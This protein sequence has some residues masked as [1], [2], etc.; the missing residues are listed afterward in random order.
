LLGMTGVLEDAKMQEGI[1]RDGGATCYASAVADPDDCFAQGIQGDKCTPY[2]CRLTLH[3]ADPRRAVAGG[4][5]I[6][7][8]LRFMEEKRRQSFSP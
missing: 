5:T 4:P 8:L 3:Y 7:H 1:G 2:C 6:D